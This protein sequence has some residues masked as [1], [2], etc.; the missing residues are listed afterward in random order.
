M[1]PG[2]QARVDAIK[3]TLPRTVRLRY[4]VAAERLPEGPLREAYIG[5][6]QLDAQVGYGFI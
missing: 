1:N 6:L 4:G 5:P 3:D 2:W